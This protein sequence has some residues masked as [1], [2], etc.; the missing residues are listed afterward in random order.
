MSTVTEQML[1]KNDLSPECQAELGSDTERDHD[2]EFLK[3]QKFTASQHLTA[4]SA[5]TDYIDNGEA[6]E[7]T[8]KWSWGLR[9]LKAMLKEARGMVTFIVIEF[10]KKQYV[11]NNI[12]LTEDQL[13]IRRPC[14]DQTYFCYGRDWDREVFSP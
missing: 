3:G 7:T 5:D 12:C 6:Q 11:M 13:I 10:V 2:H 4:D 9:H 14:R 8:E 1:V